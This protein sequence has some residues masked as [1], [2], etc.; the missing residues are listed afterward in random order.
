MEGNATLSRLLT[1]AG[2]ALILRYLSPIDSLMKATATQAGGFDDGS[3]LVSINFG[4]AESIDLQCRHSFWVLT[5]DL[6]CSTATQA[7]DV[8]L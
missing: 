2:W 1:A 8:M 6:Q 7:Y 4:G 5:I 3:V